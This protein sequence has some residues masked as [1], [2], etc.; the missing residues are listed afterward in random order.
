MQSSDLWTADAPLPGVTQRCCLFETLP[1]LDGVI[2]NHSFMSF[3][4]GVF[5]YQK[6]PIAK[7]EMFSMF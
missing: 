4:P 7:K 5:M 6:L 1:E 2:G 3:Y